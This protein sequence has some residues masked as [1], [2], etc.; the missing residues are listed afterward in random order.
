MDHEEESLTTEDL[1]GIH[2]GDKLFFCLDHV[3]DEERKAPYKYLDGTVVTVRSISQYFG[4]QIE[5][6]GGA[7][8]YVLRCF[9][10]LI[11]NP[12]EVDDNEFDAVFA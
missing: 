9:R 11:E 10:R 8:H 5:E 4:I 1:K 7:H 6:D 3:E 12:L 2:Q